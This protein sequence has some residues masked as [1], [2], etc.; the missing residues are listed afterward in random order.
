MTDAPSTPNLSG[1]SLGDFWKGLTSPSLV[2]VVVALAVN[3]A[4]LGTIGVFAR[5]VVSG[6][7]H[8]YLRVDPFDTHLPVTNRVLSYRGSENPETV[9]LGASL[10]IRCLASETSLARR[11]ES[12]LGRPIRVHRLC[13]DAQNVWEM[14]SIVE[15][16][17]PRFHGVLVLGLSP[18]T[19]AH[20]L[21]DG[22]GNGYASLERVLEQPR[23]GFVSDSLD[24][25]ARAAGLRAPRRAG[26]YAFDN[27]HFLLTRRFHLA[28]NL[29]LGPPAIG[30]LLEAPWVEHVNRPEFWRAEIDALPEKK[31]LYRSNYR[32][33]LD[34]VGRFV[35]D[36]RSRGRVGVVLLEPPTNPGWHSVP[37]AAAFFREYRENLRSFAVEHRMHFLPIT[38]EAL[39]TQSDFVDYEGHIGNPSARERCESVLAAWIGRALVEEELIPRRAL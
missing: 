9:V 18:G 20:G 23:L 26:L 31:R 35:D 39:L 37:E 5:E 22:P 12:E 19:L 10:T 21:R 30:E 11:L 4:G 14:A 13:T 15:R 7:A 36:L 34:A 3:L 28:R 38:D 25:Q 1:Q 27:M 2:S 32:T 16:L 6:K 24:A 33:A 17:G 29:L 8:R